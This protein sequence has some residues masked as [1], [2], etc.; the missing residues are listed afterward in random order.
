[1]L[2]TMALALTGA[3]DASAA[4]PATPPAIV[5]ESASATAG[6][7]SAG[8]PRLF[9]AARGGVAFP[10]NYKGVTG[11]YALDMGA[12]FRDGHQMALRLVVMPNPPDVLGPRETP[13]LAAG[14]VLAYAY[15]IPLA[16]QLDIPVGAGLGLMI[17]QSAA[18]YNK[19]LPYLQAEA[20]IRMRAKI[21]SDRQLFM[22]P[23]LGFVPLVLAPQVG[24]SVGLLGPER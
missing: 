15:N 18:G 1:M 22:T 5:A 6:A 4:T 12:N 17:G 13:P 23:S 11:S 3:L 8:H 7:T 9:A 20:G 24:I 16:P 10:M 19:M 14:P 2:L 21:A